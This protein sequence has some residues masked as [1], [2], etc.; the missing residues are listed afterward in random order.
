M[1]L[2]Q[3]LLSSIFPSRCI[4][5]QQIVL[6]HAIN[7]H[8]EICSGCYQV[9]PHNKYC[10]AHCAL[11][12]PEDVGLDCINKNDILCGRCIKQ[13]PQF[14]YSYSLFRYQDEV[15]R[16]IHR[17]KFGEKV[18]YARSIGELLLTTVV[19]K[20]LPEQGRPECIIPVPLHNRRLR[21]RG[22]NQSTE[23]SR[24]L[25]K[26]MGLAIEHDVVLRQRSTL[27]QTGLKA[28]QRQKNIK[29]A[30]KVMRRLNAKHV[31]L[32]DDVITTGSTVNELAKVLKQ[33]GIE[34]IGVLSIARAPLKS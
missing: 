14:D 15:I 31:L 13:A 18:S 33:S 20:L 24:V 27:T 16:L 22:Y 19:D 12:L 5:C 28:K 7:Q 1:E 29:G 4:L 25:S 32:V 2:A 10:C 3:R 34:R 21:Q 6:E 30:F 9:L 8:V 23:I 11:P 17:L 26:K